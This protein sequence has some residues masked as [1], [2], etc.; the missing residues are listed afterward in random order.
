MDTKPKAITI[1]L[2]EYEKMKEDLVFLTCL[3]NAGVD[4]WVGYDYALD[5]YEETEDARGGDD[6]Y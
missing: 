3:R 1:P 4:N 2:A 6:G 5:L